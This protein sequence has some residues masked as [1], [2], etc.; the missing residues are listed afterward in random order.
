MMEFSQGD[1]IQVSGFKNLFLIVSKNAF[2]RAVHMF[3]VC[4]VLK[5]VAEGP[6]HIPIKGINEYSGTVIC[7]QLKLIDPSE[8]A[9]IRKDRLSYAATV[10]ISDAIQGIFEYD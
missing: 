6:L 3:H 4:P 9:C 7:E 1:L 8:R 2:I 5:N 10:N